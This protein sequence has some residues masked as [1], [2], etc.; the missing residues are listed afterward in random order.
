MVLMMLAPSF[1]CGS[2]A[3]VSWNMAKMLV[4]KVFSHCSS[5]RSSS[6]FSGCCSAALLTRMSRRPQRVMT[7][8]TTLR[9]N[10]ASAA[11][12]ARA[13][14]CPPLRTTSSTVF[15]AS[16]FSSR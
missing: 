9:Q 6:C 4:R 15:F 10:P 11:S 12:P 8:P 14:A 2:A 3:L 5:S 7:S 1:I 13:M 16:S